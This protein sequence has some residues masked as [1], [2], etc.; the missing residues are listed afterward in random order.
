[1][2]QTRITLNPQ[3]VPLAEELLQ[4]TG[5]TNLSN[6]F[7]LLLT[8]YGNHLKNSWVIAVS[9]TTAASMQETASMQA[10]PHELSQTEPMKQLPQSQDPVIQRM[11]R[12]IEDF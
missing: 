1:M 6:L 7:C 9:S 12:L 5:V 10:F 11:A 8:R 2:S 3:V 4:L